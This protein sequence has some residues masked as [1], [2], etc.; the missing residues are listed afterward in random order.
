M[1]NYFADFMLKLGKLEIVYVPG[2]WY[3]FH[4]STE[5]SKQP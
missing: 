3:L 2:T 5:L 4:F 1:V